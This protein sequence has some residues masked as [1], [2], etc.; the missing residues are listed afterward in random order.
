MP[1]T[2]VEALSTAQRSLAA[3]AAHD[4]SGWIDLFT[5][6][7]QVEDP[8]GSRPHRGRAAIA[9]FYDTFIGPRSITFDAGGD[10][11]VGTTVVRDVELQI[12]MSPTLTM[13][14]PTFIRYD[15]RADKGDLKIAALSAYWELPAMIVQF[16]RGGPAAIPSGAALGRA[17]LTHQGIGGCL[18]FLRGFRRVRAGAARRFTQLLDDACSGDEIG[19][20]RAAAEASCFHGDTLAMT[21][22]DLVTQLSGCSWDKLIRSG[23]SVA[24]RIEGAGAR[25]VLIG[26]F[27]PDAT[28][29][30]LRLFSTAA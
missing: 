20:R 18:G 25:A 2:P 28:L 16:A 23:G 21:T 19:L 29:A 15:V 9:R 26:E 17:M 5:T 10:V 24:A 1:I 22:S 8:V 7:G 27:G 14:V 4:R 11:V 3:A 30:R 13:R 12:A 6:D